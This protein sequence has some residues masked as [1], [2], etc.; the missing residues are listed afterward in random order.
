MSGTFKATLCDDGKWVVHDLGDVIAFA[1]EQDPE[2][3]EAANV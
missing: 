3:K 1:D 2:T